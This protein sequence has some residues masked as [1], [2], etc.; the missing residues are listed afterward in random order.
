MFCPC[1]C[2]SQ[3]LLSLSHNHYRTMKMMSSSY[4]WWTTPLSEKLLYPPFT[5]L[6]RTGEYYSQYL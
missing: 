5:Y 3:F 2:V 4:R 6:G 1:L